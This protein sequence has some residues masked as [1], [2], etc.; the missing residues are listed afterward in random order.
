M[1]FLLCYGEMHSGE[2]F[3]QFFANDCLRTCR[4]KQKNSHQTMGR[5][6][7]FKIRWYT[8][9]KERVLITDEIAL[10]CDRNVLL[11]LNMVTYLGI[12]DEHRDYSNSVLRSKLP[13]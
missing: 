7:S 8:Y 2:I 3:V 6:F 11:D 10:T 1:L 5:K 12:G 13:T 4:K 9:V